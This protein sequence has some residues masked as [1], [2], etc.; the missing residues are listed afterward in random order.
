EAIRVLPEAETPRA[1]V[2]LLFDYAAC[3]ATEIQPHGHDVDAL[4]RAMDCY[5]AARSLGV[6]VDVIGPDE[7]PAP[8]KVLIIPG[9]VF[10]SDA[11]VQKVCDSDTRCLVFARSG[12][13]AADFSIPSQLAP[14][15]L[16]RLLPLRVS[17]VDSMRRGAQRS[18]DWEDRPY[19]V[20]RWY[21]TLE[22]DLEPRLRL[23]D[24]SGLW[25][26]HEG[27]HYL[28]GITSA[29]F[30]ALVL[31]EML[32]EAKLPY[33]KLPEGLRLRRRGPLTFAFNFS[34]ETREFKPDNQSLLLGHHSL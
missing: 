33:E 3:W 12:S 19:A 28:N 21:E 22:T 30:S 7:D 20:E 6:D 25:Y 2:A 32:V 8:Y 4:R 31:E 10:V 5:G 14:G 9:T 15:S 26:T 18:F 34:P 27:H 24:G 16:Q 29:D 1:S 23:K 17:A 11:L 13:R